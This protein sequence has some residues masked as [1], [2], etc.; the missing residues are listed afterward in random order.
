[1]ETL[2]LRKVRTAGAH[3]MAW[4]AESG[5]RERVGDV[6]TAKPT[7]TTTTSTAR[8][9]TLQTTHETHRGESQPAHVLSLCSTGVVVAT[10]MLAALRAPHFARAVEPHSLAYVMRFW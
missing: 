7:T 9:D 4:Y 6:A 2:C 3:G 8:D 10:C 5:R 1:M